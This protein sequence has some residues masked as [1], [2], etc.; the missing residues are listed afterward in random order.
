M[1]FLSLF[2]NNPGHNIFKLAPIFPKQNSGAPEI[3]QFLADYILHQTEF[4][5]VKIITLSDNHHGKIQNALNFFLFILQ[6]L[7]NDMHCNI[8][9]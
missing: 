7:K 8:T 2:P 3:M 9:L 6:P 4:Q 1:I 5:P